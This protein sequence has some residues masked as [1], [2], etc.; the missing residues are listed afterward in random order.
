[1]KNF[2]K[3]VFK[4]TKDR[5]KRKLLLIIV[6]ALFL[7]GLLIYVGIKNELIYTVLALISIC[8]WI[9][10]DTARDLDIDELKEEVNL[11]KYDMKKLKKQKYFRTKKN[12]KQKLYSFQEK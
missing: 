8:V 6:T 5:K 9:L 4:F 11:L 2:F 1:M 3:N 7:F 10:A 12:R